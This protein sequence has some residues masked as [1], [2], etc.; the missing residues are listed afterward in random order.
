MGL[1]NF[2]A[3]K[4]STWKSTGIFNYFRN[5]HM[6]AIADSG[7]DLPAL[8]NDGRLNVYLSGL[9]FNKIK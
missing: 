4:I 5:S 2:T 9:I 6:N 7:G 1:F 8:K 3:G